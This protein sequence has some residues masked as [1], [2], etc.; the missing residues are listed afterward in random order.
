[1]LVLALLAYLIGAQ[2]T[3]HLRYASPLERLA[4]SVAL[5]FGVEGLIVFV[6]GIAGLLCRVALVIAAIGVIVLSF[7]V[8]RS[9]GR[10]LC[11][12]MQ[13]LRHLGRRKVVVRLLALLV[14]AV[15]LGP[16]LLLP[17]YPPTAWD[18]TS[19]HLPIAK[20]YVESQRIV[21]AQFLRYPLFPQLG[22]MLF[23]AVLAFSDAISAQLTQFVMLAVLLAGCVAF[24]E[25][26]FSR[27]SG[28]WAAA[29]VASY[30]LV[31]WAASVAYID[32][33]LMTYVFFAIYALEVA[34]Q[35]RDKKWFILCGVFAGFAAGTK[36]TALFFAGMLSLLVLI[37][38]F[39]RRDGRGLISYGASLLLVAS[40]WYVRNLV[41]AGNPVWPF[42]SEV[43][44]FWLWNPDDLRRQMQ[45]LAHA[46][47]VGRSLI[48][49]L[50][51]PWNLSQ[52]IY[53]YHHEAPF[54][55][56]FLGLPLGFLGIKHATVRRLMLIAF[57]FL[58]FWFLTT[59]IP[60]Y[61][62]PVLPIFS[63]LT[64][65]AGDQLLVHTRLGNRE[66]GLLARPLVV[67]LGVVLF[68]C[69]GWVYGV[70]SLSRLGPIPV[71]PQQREGFLTSRL[72]T[73]KAYAFL[74]SLRGNDYVLY[75]L[76]NENMA[77]FA[78]GVFMGDHFGVARYS[79]LLSPPVDGKVLYD[80]LRRLG[81]DHLLVNLFRSSISFPLPG[82]DWFEE[83]FVVLFADAYVLLYELTEAPV[84]PVESP[85]LLRNPGFEELDAHL[86][87]GWGVAGSPM[88]ESSRPRTGKLAVRSVGASNAC[89]QRVPVEEGALYVL[90]QFVRA[91]TQEQKARLQV[92]WL[93]QEGD[94]LSTSIRVIEVHA[95]WEQHEMWVTAPRGAAYAE[96][97]AS[98][99]EDSVACFDDFSFVRVSYGN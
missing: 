10:G 48:D 8:W 1:M 74:N 67:L 38:A 14:L 62:L 73:Y 61:L 15:V 31:I 32:A 5:G 47:V 21:T 84:R 25:R 94:F 28:L 46:H 52:R 85:E 70:T 54:S 34:I 16:F 63:I 64:A 56:V 82:D 55:P 83:H 49:F 79:D 44:G 12:G 27:R 89:F 99:H 19:Y 66:K 76:Y 97:Y 77:F 88:L 71:T 95:K 23:A 78:E 17:L 68:M 22:E 33:A 93:N 36:Y 98:A 91:D 24:C 65:W 81:A 35:E 7:P 45:D 69:P 6:L 72:P 18:S 92:N 42:L 30:P 87:T 20:L 37:D 26:F 11:N 43:F 13:H 9:W 96:V 86:P 51:L 59:Q 53:L 90:R 2:L 80:R 57:S 58:G 4:L 29:M 40:P 60:R 50:R 75:A 41:I 3:Q 39:Q